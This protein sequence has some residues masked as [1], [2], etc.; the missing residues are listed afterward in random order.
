MELRQWLEEV[1]RKAIDFVGLIRRGSVASGI[2][3]ECRMRRERLIRPTMPDTRHVKRTQRQDHRLVIDAGASEFPAVNTP[4]AP[5]LRPIS[6]IPV[7]ATSRDQAP[8]L[9]A[10]S[11]ESPQ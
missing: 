9:H 3:T 8:H 6:S 4:I 7:N 5:S 2:V 10:L 11:A 1:L